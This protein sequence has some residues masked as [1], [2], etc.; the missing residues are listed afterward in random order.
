LYRADWGVPADIPDNKYFDWVNAQ[1]MPKIPITE[2]KF[3][4]PDYDLEPEIRSLPGGE[5]VRLPRL[6][7]RTVGA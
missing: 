2:L 7:E 4:C 6:V 5:K 3:L 1:F